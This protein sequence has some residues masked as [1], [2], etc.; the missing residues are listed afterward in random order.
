MVRQTRWIVL[1][2]ALFAAT[3]L[4]AD[5]RSSLLDVK[6]AG[7]QRIAATEY[8]EAS[9][10]ASRGGAPLAIALAIVGPFEGVTQHLIQVNQ[11]SE[12]P[13]ASRLTVVRDGLLDD[14]VRG[15]RWEIALEK[16]AAGGWTISEVKRAWRCRRGAQTHSFAASRC[17]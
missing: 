5:R 12:A 15:E 3:G 2:A 8:A 14:S 1:S 16:T 10:L 17:P 11:G 6:V 7:M 4:A 9:A 13:T